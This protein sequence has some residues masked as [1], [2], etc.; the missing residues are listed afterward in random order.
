MRTWTVSRIFAILVGSALCISTLGTVSAAR[1]DSTCNNLLNNI[2]SILSVNPLASAS[3]IHTTNFLVQSTTTL[4]WF[5]GHTQVTLN[6]VNGHLV[7]S[8]NRLH[9]DRFTDSTRTQPFDIHQ[10]EFISYDIDPS[11]KLTLDGIYGP[12]DPVCFF[13]KFMVV[14]GATAVEVFSFVITGGLF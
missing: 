4:N 7:G 5:G 14:P 6:L 11:G 1:A 2:R 3:V 8:D 10:P 13:D 12:A 9:S